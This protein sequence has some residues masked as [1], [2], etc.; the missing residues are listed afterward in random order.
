MIYGFFSGFFIIFEIGWLTG[1]ATVRNEIPGPFPVVYYM[2]LQTSVHFPNP[3]SPHQ[4]IQE[5]M[6][7]VVQ[8]GAG[9]ELKC[10]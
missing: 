9:S 8:R 1:A 3:K 7:N 4:E 6:T 2:A 5:K 10:F